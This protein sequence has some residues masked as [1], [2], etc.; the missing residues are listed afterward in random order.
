MK[1]IDEQNKIVEEN[2]QKYQSL[3][4]SNDD[5]LNQINIEINNMKEEYESK[6]VEFE[7]INKQMEL[8]LTNNN[9]NENTS[10]A[11]LN[12]IDKMNITQLKDIVIELKTQLKDIT[13]KYTNSEKKKRLF[14]KNKL[15]K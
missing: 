5:Q 15:Q 14:R 2:H 7:N 12:K 6:L 8:S 4:K 9:N 10:N 1:N 3:I 13:I 11:I